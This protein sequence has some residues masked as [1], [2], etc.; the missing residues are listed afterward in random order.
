[1]RIIALKTLKSFWTKYPD[2]EEPLRLWYKTTEKAHW[3]SFIKVRETF[4]T[5]DT[6]KVYSGNTV[7]IFDIGGNKYRLITSIHYDVFCVYAML[8]LTHK[9]Y[10]RNKWKEQL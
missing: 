2:A 9:E 10:D 5:A 1:M 7:T 3:T 6:A 4:G 8:V